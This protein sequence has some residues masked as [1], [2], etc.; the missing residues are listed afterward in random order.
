MKERLP[1]EIT[2]GP[3]FHRKFCLPAGKARLEFQ[4][5]QPDRPLSRMTAVLL[6]SLSCFWCFGPTLSRA[7]S[8]PSL[9]THRR[10]RT[11]LNARKRGLATRTGVPRDG[12]Y[13]VRHRHTYAVTLESVTLC[14][15]MSH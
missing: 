12:R 4:V 1:T 11:P 9:S 10:W 7:L 5:P 6:L 8:H 14:C 13:P 3:G 2:P 15:I